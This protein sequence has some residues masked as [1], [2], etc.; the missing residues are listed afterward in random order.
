MR[1]RAHQGREAARKETQALM[2]RRTSSCL[3]GYRPALP[4]SYRSLSPGDRDGDLFGGGFACTAVACRRRSPTAQLLSPNTGAR[5]ISQCYGT[6]MSKLD[7]TS[8]AFIGCAAARPWRT[9]RRNRRPRPRLRRPRRALR[10][11]PDPMHVLLLRLGLLDLP[12]VRVGDFNA[13]RV[14]LVIWRFPPREKMELEVEWR[15]RHPA[16][17]LRP[18]C[19]AQLK[20][21]T[22]L[23]LGRASDEDD[24]P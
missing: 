7:L 16:P 11:V 12:V 15:E 8:T 6:V 17:L 23:A 3:A 2:H 5:Q 20:E 19:L 24:L 10:G 21:K 22:L 13:C 4:M 9:R 18:G 1:R 14:Q